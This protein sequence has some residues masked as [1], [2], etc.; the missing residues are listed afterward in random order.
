MPATIDRQSVAAA[1]HSASRAAAAL[2][3]GDLRL[4]LREQPVHPAL[5]VKVP[6]QRRS[7]ENNATQT[8]AIS[9]P[10]TAGH[11]GV[12]YRRHGLAVARHDVEAEAG[13]A[14]QQH[15]LLAGRVVLRVVVAV[16]GP[17]P[18]DVGLGEV[19]DA[20]QRPVLL[21]HTDL[22][23]QIEVLLPMRS[24]HPELEWARYGLKRVKESGSPGRAGPP[25]PE[26]GRSSRSGRS[27][28][29]SRRWS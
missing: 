6:C 2:T 4:H 25:A 23:E 10:L 20:G 8:A 18:R 27:C 28:A 1:R 29:R 14:R 9:W 19:I 11:V 24:E 21:L 16:V 13:A 7:R 15:V 3:P 12:V 26:G 22:V 17:L 5:Q